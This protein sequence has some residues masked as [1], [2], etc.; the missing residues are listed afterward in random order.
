MALLRVP[1]LGPV[2]VRR[3]LG[4]RRERGRIRSIDEIGRPGKR[5]R[6]AAQYLQF[7]YQSRV[8]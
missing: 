7:G 2:T 1:G 6:K 8:A 3:I 5:L 4:I